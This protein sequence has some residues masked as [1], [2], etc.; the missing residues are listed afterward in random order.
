MYMYMC[1]Y[2]YI[3]PFLKEKQRED[4]TSRNP[5]KE[6]HLWMG[7]KTVEEMEMSELYVFKY[8]FLT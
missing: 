7:Y 3:K 4:K 8:S 6:L 5:Y 1:I 2:I